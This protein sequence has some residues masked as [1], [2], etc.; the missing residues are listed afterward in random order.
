M[1]LTDSNADA[2]FKQFPN[3]WDI[4]ELGEVCLVD[5]GNT[6]LTKRT[7]T[8]KGFPAYSASGQDGLVEFYEHE[9]DA[10]V[11]SAIGARCGK[12]FWAT[13]KWTAIKNTIVIKP[14]D[15]SKVDM[16][17]LY[18]R[19][20]DESFWPR[21]GTGQP[22]IGI[23]RAKIQ[24]IPLPPLPEQRA[25]AHVLSTIRQAIDA[26][27]GVIAAAQELKR[28]MM[29]HLFTYGPVP[30][31]QADKVLLK[32]TE[33]GEI[34]EYWNTAPFQKTLKKGRIDVGKVKK[35]DYLPFGTFPII[36]QSREFVSG[37]WNDDTIVYKGELPV[38]IF[39][40]HTRVF[41]YVNFPFI[42]GADGT[43]VLLP[44][45]KLVNPE[46]YFYSLNQLNIPSKGYSRHYK[47]LKEQFIP[48]PP[49]D[50]QKAIADYLKTLKNKIDLEE[51]LKYSQEAFFNSLLHHLMTGKVRVK[52]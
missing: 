44:K 48:I 15:L 30:V 4:V 9:G 37:Y 18:F 35:Q 16:R 39:G 38:V 36:D 14:K 23:G 45:E 10:V 25:I 6:S 49:M 2:E 28:S 41:K 1:V 12:C 8:N 11:L 7:Y 47:L 43:K 21:S 5:W 51:N 42:C 3:E 46:Y 33:I 13:G 26:T 24:N 29:K 22:F 31:D 40:D 20:N 50:E 17:Y 32:E 34:P 52:I 27:E 19:V